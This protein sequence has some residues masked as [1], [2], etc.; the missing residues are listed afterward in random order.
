MN[1]SEPLN[2][3]L[4]QLSKIKILRFLIKVE[5]AMNGRE[6]AQAVGLSHVK[7]HI[8][9][10]ELS[11]Q[12]IISVRQVG[13]SNLYELQSDHILIREWL[14]PLFRKEQGLKK[15][16]AGMLVHRLSVRPE[17]LIIFGSVAKGEER[18]DSDI[19]LLCV[20]S[21]RL[22]LKKCEK[23]LFKVGEEVARLFGN[24]LA[25]HVIAKKALLNKF[26]RR[27][28]FVRDVAKTGE[29]IYGKTISEMSS[30]AAR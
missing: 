19:D 20:V 27:D 4:G 18:P 26:K 22:A 7:C 6:I 13:R 14:R 9:L 5:L 15:R 11:A 25:P 8:A 17:S 3:V 12:G 30:D 1:F 21:D 29:V 10:K 28:Q 24:R 23:E 16:F 2:R